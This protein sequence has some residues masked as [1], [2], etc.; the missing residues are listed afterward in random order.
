MGEEE[1]KVRRAPRTGG[2]DRPKEEGGR[3][4]PR[5][6]YAEIFLP[7]NLILLPCTAKKKLIAVQEFIAFPKERLI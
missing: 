5:L 2:M 6:I 1:R 7:M 3:R 4:A